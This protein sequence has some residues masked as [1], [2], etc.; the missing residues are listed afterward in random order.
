VQ[1]G[2][3]KNGYDVVSDM[4]N[5]IMIWRWSNMRGAGHLHLC[6]SWTKRING[7]RNSGPMQP[8]AA[9]GRWSISEVCLAH[10]L[11]VT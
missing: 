11:K 10:H 4:Y 1:R 5:T 3:V 6:R 8:D 2:L 7:A 9:S